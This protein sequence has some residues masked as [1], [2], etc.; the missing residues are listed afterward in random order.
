MAN[1]SATIASRC[2]IIWYSAVPPSMSVRSKMRIIFLAMIVTAVVGCAA[3]RLSNFVKPFV[4]RDIHELTARL[5]NPAGKRETTGNSVYVWSADS[6]G[7]L[8]TTTSADGTRTN[9]MTVQYECTLEVTVNAQN[10][11]QSYE[12]EGSDAGCAA[13]R[14]HLK[15]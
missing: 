9:T 11:I 14:R 6:E 2:V 13:F 12:I 3:A 8:P 5:G 15:R 10:V 4:G 7:V 1:Q